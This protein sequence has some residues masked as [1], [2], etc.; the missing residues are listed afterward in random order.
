VRFLQVSFFTESTSSSGPSTHCSFFTLVF[1]T[2]RCMGHVPPP[3]NQLT[4]MCVCT[5]VTVSS[6]LTLACWQHFLTIMAINNN[7]LWHTT[8]YKSLFYK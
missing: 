3:N 8:S 1:Y 7:F 2:I 5:S 6:P 4:Y